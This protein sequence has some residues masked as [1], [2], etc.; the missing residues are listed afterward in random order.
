LLL[1]PAEFD[2]SQPITV[3]VNGRTAF[4]RR[5]EPSVATLMKW[6]ARDNDRTALFGAEVPIKV[7]DGL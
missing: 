3:T 4:Q 6:A 7:G 2:F 5:A 1:S